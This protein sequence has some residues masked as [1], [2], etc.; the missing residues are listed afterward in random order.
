MMYDAEMKRLQM[1]IDEDL[2][3]ALERLARAERTSKAA[4]IRRYVRDRVK[5]HPPLDA[6]SL[7][8]MAGVDDFDPASVDEIVYR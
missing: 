8:R 7:W 1:M 2:D 6:D 5:G 3:E 4:L